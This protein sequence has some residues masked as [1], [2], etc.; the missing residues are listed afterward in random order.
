VDQEESEQNEIDR[1]KEEVDFIGKVM[2]LPRYKTP[3][4]LFD[5]RKQSLV[6]CNEEDA[7]LILNVR[8]GF[9]M[10]CMIVLGLVVGRL[11]LRQLQSNG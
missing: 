3:I 6:F 5:Y 9:V 11:L 2:H 7:E 10:Y 4:S 8:L 1:M